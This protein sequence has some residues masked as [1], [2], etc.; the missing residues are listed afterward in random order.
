MSRSKLTPWF[1][2]KQHKP[3]RPGVYQLLCGLRKDIGYQYW[4]GRFWHGW[5]KTPDEA[6]KSRWIA[7]GY[8][9]DNWRGLRAQEG[10]KP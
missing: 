3:A 9:N 7:C 4:D 10:P 5:H 2:G 8:E 6:E 1:D